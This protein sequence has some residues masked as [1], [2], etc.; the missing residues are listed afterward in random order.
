MVHSNIFYCCLL[1]TNQALL[2]ILRL[3]SVDQ[4][5]VIETLNIFLMIFGKSSMFL[6][7]WFLNPD[8]AAKCCRVSYFKMGLY[9]PLC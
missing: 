2:H 5:K 8:D 6:C 7:N 1:I 4:N 9:I 3:F